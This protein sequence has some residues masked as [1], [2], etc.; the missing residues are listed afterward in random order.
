MRMN[1][2]GTAHSLRS[3]FTLFEV[4]I[5]LMIVSV[6]VITV[7]LLLPAGVK[8]HQMS[9]YQLYAS[10]KAN[11]LV[12]NF[13]Q[14]GQD[15]K[16]RTMFNTY[17]WA[18]AVDM[19]K[20]HTDLTGTSTQFDLERMSV[21]AVQGN[22][23]VPLNIAAR[24]DSPGNEIQKILDQGGRIHYC[25]PYPSKV[26]SRGQAATGSK[27]VESPELQKLIW[28]VAGFAQQNLLPCDVQIPYAKEPWP[29]PPL[30]RT[31]PIMRRFS[32][33]VFTRWTD[34][35]DAT[36]T[37]RGAWHYRVLNND[38]DLQTIS[39]QSGFGYQERKPYQGNNWEWLAY[40]DESNPTPGFTAA[41]KWVNGRDEFRRMA[42]YHW[43]RIV[44]QLARCGSGRSVK[45]TESYAPP[46]DYKLPWT[47][48]STVPPALPSGQWKDGSNPGKNVPPPTTA[49]SDIGMPMPPTGLPTSNER[50][51]DI[52]YEDHETWSKDW[53]FQMR[54]GMPSL[55]RRVMYRTAALALWAKVC[56]AAPIE[57]NAHPL[58]DIGTPADI[59]GTAWDPNVATNVA[60][61]DGVGM[62][63][64][65]SV[66]PPPNPGEIS[67]AQVL[68][69]SYLA[70]ASLMV[71]GYKPPFID[72]PRDPDPSGDRNLISGHPTYPN[73]A[74]DRPYA[75]LEKEAI[76]AG[77]T[78]NLAP[79]NYPVQIYSWLRAPYPPGNANP[80]DPL[81]PL[82]DA[83][84]A[85]AAAN[86]LDPAVSVLSG[87]TRHC[88]FA[89]DADGNPIRYRR[90][91]G[92]FSDNNP[93]Q[94]V[95]NPNPPPYAD[96]GAFDY[97]GRTVANPWGSVDV[98]SPI[99]LPPDSPLPPL[100]LVQTCWRLWQGSSPGIV[101]PGMDSQ[102]A[103]NAHE[104]FIRW[105]MAYI[106]ENPYDVI[107]P[108]PFNRQ[109]MTDKPLYAWNLFDGLGNARRNPVGA[110]PVDAVLRSGRGGVPA[111][112][113]IRTGR[114]GG[115]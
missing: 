71:T 99:V 94:M 109:T 29:F 41:S 90:N 10:V 69:L 34:K 96:T 60:A 73:A 75:V 78:Y 49:P 38:T 44:H 6:A 112:Q 107:V 95:V 97:A 17:Q 20:V 37:I 26:F 5:S 64:L 54:R 66:I 55:Q 111:Q 93:S 31:T 11:E 51:T 1:R 72:N 83:Q 28:G 4:G 45:E 98:I 85:I 42:N 12:E 32:R 24:L 70:H 102:Y 47:Y 30:A 81:P 33:Q 106:S 39:V 52:L 43:M 101:P 113:P 80:P 2:H 76:P 16:E 68:A 77:S 3:G 87:G 62:N 61:L 105:A 19:L 79:Y 57:I 86:P 67:A 23:P 21:N 89:L 7:L 91:D 92:V 56:T 63:P 53:D 104:T 65:T 100:P 46:L 88:I 110:S 25:D 74:P 48:V 18:G 9:R 84:A 50:G 82:T 15:F 114:G 14:T 58:S 8:A 108:R 22:F 59:H 36:N 103:R 115:A 35:D 40:Q 13:A 27:K